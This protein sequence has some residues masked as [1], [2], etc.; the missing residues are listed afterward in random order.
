[1]ENLTPPILTIA[2]ELLWKISSGQSMRAAMQSQ[3]SDDPS[4]FAVR[5]REWW[6]RYLQSPEKTAAQDYFTTPYQLA[7]TELIVRGTAGQPVLEML[8]TLTAE[9][10]RVAE[11]CLESHVQTLPFKQLIPLLIFQFPAFLVLL[12]G[13]LLREL[14]TGLGG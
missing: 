5:M 10:E 14:Q 9:I 13:P 3:L 1:M 6:T 8:K 11:D 4:P 12:V 7:L 2:R